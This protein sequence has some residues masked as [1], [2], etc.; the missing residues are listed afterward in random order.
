MEI[1]NDKEV[2]NKYFVVKNVHLN[3]NV[4]NFSN[5]MNIYLL[6]NFDDFQLLIRNHLTMLN[7]FFQEYFYLISFVHHHLIQILFY[8]LKL[9]FK[10][11]PLI[12][13]D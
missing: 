3:D 8:L 12:K 6:K 10:T 4:Q 5:L 2:L 9:F 11:N 13:I 7:S 1:E